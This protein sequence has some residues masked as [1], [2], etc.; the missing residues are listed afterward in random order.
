MGYDRGDN[1]L[2]DFELCHFS[3]Y[4]QPNSGTT[5][6]YIYVYAHI[7]IYFVSPL[8]AC[9]GRRVLYSP[10]SEIYPLG[11]GLGPRQVPIRI[12]TLTGTH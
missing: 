9:S 8:A 11:L 3:A 2:F 1:F 5:D 12:R 4:K 6:I 7:Y 10:P